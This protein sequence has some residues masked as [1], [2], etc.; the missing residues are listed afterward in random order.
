MFLFALNDAPAC[1]A[2]DSAHTTI[3]HIFLFIL[4]DVPMRGTAIK[5][6]SVFYKPYHRPDKTRVLFSP[7][8]S[9]PYELRPPKFRG[10]LQDILVCGRWEISDGPALCG[11][12]WGFRNWSRI[13]N[14][15]TRARAGK[16]RHVLVE[17]QSSCILEP[18]SKKH[19]ALRWG[20]PSGQ[21]K[22]GLS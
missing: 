3:L 12:G 9:P 10:G 4:N 8:I 5:F 6:A 16:L 14:R 17:A 7:P 20:I 2:R 19:L 21:A 15:S 11:F 13:K 18:R 22:S 1:D